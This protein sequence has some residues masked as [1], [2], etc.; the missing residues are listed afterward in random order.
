MILPLGAMV[1]EFIGPSQGGGLGEES[2]GYED[3]ITS[4]EVLIGLIYI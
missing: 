4:V 1:E 2:W 3:S